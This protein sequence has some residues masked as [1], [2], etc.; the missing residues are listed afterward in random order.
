MT[1][2]ERLER[3]EAAHLLGLTVEILEGLPWLLH[4]PKDKESEAYKET[5]A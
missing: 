3:L 1:L 4:D 2:S 5:E